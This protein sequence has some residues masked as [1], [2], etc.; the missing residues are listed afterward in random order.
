MVRIQ[1][2][3]SL[4]LNPFLINIAK[5]TPNENYVDLIYLEGGWMAHPISSLG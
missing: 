3:V 1:S 4:I 5:S 2:K